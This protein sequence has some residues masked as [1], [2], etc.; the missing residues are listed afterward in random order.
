MRVEEYIEQ[1]S[2]VFVL[3]DSFLRIKELVDDEEST[4]DD[5]SEVRIT[6]K[7][8]YVSTLLFSITTSPF[9]VLTFMKTIIVAIPIQTIPR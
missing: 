4:I 1:V 6:R 8:K 3:S 7:S 5:I 2:D 9:L